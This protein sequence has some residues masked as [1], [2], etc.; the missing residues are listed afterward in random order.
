[1]HL[2]WSKEEA[3][4]FHLYSLNLLGKKYPRGKK[5][6]HQCFEDLDVI[7]IDPL[8]ILG[9]NHDLVIQARVDGTHPNDTLDLMHKERLGFEYWDKVYCA[10]PI[11]HFPTARAYMN[12]KSSERWEAS[13]LELKKKHPRCFELV[14][15]AVEESGPISSLELK[16]L[17]LGHTGNQGWSSS[18]VAN[19]ALEM[20]W[21]K[22]KLSI[23][24]RE[25]NRKYFDLTERVIPKTILDQKPAT[26]KGYE[27]EQF[28]RRVHNV[29]LLPK[30]GDQLVWQLASYAKKSGLAD[31]LVEKDEVALIKIEGVKYPCYASP[32]AAQMLVV[33]KQTSLGRKARFIAPLDPF[34]WSRN[35]VEEL[36]DFVYRWEVYTPPKKRVWGYY[37]LPILYRNKI[38][39]RFDG[40]YD[41]KSGILYVP[42]YH[43]EPKGLDRNHSAVEFAFSKFLEYLGGEK[44]VFGK[45]PKAK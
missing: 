34:I 29:G 18:S 4:L 40:K 23:S 25:A 32:N 45:S 11:K 35:L 30:A 43:K 37:V 44:T 9:R 10:I 1:M 12:A 3:R 28:L 38:V 8:P 6:I 14:Y 36:W 26:W 27:K 7:Q 31:K 22:G 24:H 20:L 5:G 39:G 17:D 16:Q 21:H 42:A 41:K 13:R 2:K 33:A 19:A 15:Q